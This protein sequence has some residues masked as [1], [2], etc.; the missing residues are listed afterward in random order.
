MAVDV[1][2]ALG[3]IPLPEMVRLADVVISSTH[4]WLLGTHGGGLVG[5]RASKAH[6]VT[7]NAG[8]WFHLQDPFGPDRFTDARPQPGAA[9]FSVG[10]PN[11]P[12][13]YGVLAGISYVA[14]IG[15]QEI[16]SAAAPLVAACLEGLQQ[17]PVQLISPTDPAQLAGI[18]AVLHPKLV[19]IGERLRAE[20]IHVMTQ[21]GRLR[22]SL[23]G[24]NR[25]ADVEA[26][27]AGLKAA[28]TAV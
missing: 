17:L 7:S 18:V 21:A 4:K 27:M 12:A 11:Y 19:E 13:I 14:E 2:Q 3:R 28:L 5:V 10:M 1:T 22:V 8:G 20:N 26:L 23:H 15:I 16:A 9:S 6:R 24:Y 25:M